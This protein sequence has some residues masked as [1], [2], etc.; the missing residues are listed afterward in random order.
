MRFPR[1]LLALALGA[2]ACSDPVEPDPNPDAAIDAGVNMEMASSTYT[3]H[4]AALVER[5]VRD[6]VSVIAAEADGLCA[7]HP[8]ED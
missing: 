6:R 5:G 8:L 7:E 1:L 3:E 4:L 2:A